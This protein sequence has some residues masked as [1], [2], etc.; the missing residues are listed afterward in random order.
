M[1]GPGASLAAGTRLYRR[2]IRT[3]S[4]HEWCKSAHKVVEDSAFAGAG[5]SPGRPTLQEVTFP[6]ALRLTTASAPKT[7]RRSP[8]EL[9][10]LART[11]LGKAD[12]AAYKSLFAE[13]AEETDEHRRF[14]GRLTL[15]EAAMGSSA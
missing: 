12:V 14:R 11:Y 6:M 9:A 5:R 3:S 4:S 13:V 2:R 7:A 15:L 1:A 10:A 8:A